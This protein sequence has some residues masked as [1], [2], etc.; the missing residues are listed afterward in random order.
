[1]SLIRILS[2]LFNF[3]IPIDILKGM[4]WFLSVFMGFFNFC[5]YS[6]K[7]YVKFFKLIVPVI[8]EKNVGMMSQV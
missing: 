2:I 7:K 6:V 8:T 4:N 1:M 3:F 5:N